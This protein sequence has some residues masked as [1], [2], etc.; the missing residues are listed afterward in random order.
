M[1]QRVDVRPELL[2]WTVARS[3]KDPIPDFRRTMR[4]VEA[5]RLY[6]EGHLWQ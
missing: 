4:A 3:G 1:S 5:S 6:Q 2:R